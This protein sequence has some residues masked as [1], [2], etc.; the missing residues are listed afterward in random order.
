MPKHYSKHFT[1]T[2]LFSL[3]IIIGSS[4]IIIT[5]FTDDITEA[6]RNLPKITQRV[7]ARAEIFKSGSIFW[8]LNQ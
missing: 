2:D 8:T 1:D 6:Y 3:Y 5:H 4:S 7:N